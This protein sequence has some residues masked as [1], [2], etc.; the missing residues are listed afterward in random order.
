MSGVKGKSG[1]RKKPARIIKDALDK[2]MTDDL[3]QLLQT[4]IDKGKAG[5]IE[6]AIYMVDRLLGKPKQ[7]TEIL[8]GEKIGAGTLVSL[9]TLLQERRRQYELDTPKLIKEGD[10]GQKGTDQT[11]ST[12]LQRAESVT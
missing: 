3:P 9:F 4:L 2:A 12:A 1:P 6:S 11:E 5:H 10:N 8:G 7:Q